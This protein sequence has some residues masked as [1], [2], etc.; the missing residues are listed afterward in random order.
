MLLIELCLMVL[1]VPFA[2]LAPRLAARWFTWIERRI[3]RFAARCKLAVLTIFLP[4]RQ[5][6]RKT[7]LLLATSVLSIVGLSLPAYFEAHYAAPVCSV[8]YA[9]ELQVLRRIRFWDFRGKRRGRSLVRYLITT[10]LFL[11]V[12]RAF[13]GDLHFP[14]PPNFVRTWSG[15]RPGNFARTAILD[16]LAQ[17]P[18]QHLIITRYPPSHEPATE[19]V[20]NAA[21]IDGSKG[22]LARYMG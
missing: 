13:V 7:G 11:L 6:G 22:T 1:V 18:R 21:D 17:Q 15:T 4:L 9:L 3:S 12:V 16:S 2:F 14:S 19:W 20:Y 8:F 5:L 10:C